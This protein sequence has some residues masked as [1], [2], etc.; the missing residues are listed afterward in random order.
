MA[1]ES[2]DHPAPVGGRIHFRRS[3]PDDDAAEY[4]VPARLAEQGIRFAY[5]LADAVDECEALNS[6]W[7][8]LGTENPPYDPHP[9]AG[10]KGWY[11]FMDDLETLSQHA[12]G[13]IIVVDGAAN[14]FADPSSWGFELITV[15]V[16]QLPRWQRQLA[17]LWR[18]MSAFDPLRTFRSSIQ[19]CKRRS[20][21][22]TPVS[23]PPPALPG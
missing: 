1:Y 12:A 3:E 16:L 9:P 20:R 23:L 15:W 8:Q 17:T 21:E 19:D 2:L 18:Q 14:L 6:L 11:R 7:R 4:V 13:L 22:A 10:M 5:V